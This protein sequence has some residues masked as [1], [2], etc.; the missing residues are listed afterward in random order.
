MAASSMLIAQTLAYLFTKNFATM[1]CSIQCCRLKSGNHPESQA[2]FS[3]ALLAIVRL[4]NL[5][6]AMDVCG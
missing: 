1:P 3:Y 2:H 4:N 6:L 5:S